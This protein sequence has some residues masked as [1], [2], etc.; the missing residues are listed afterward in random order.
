VILILHHAR[1]NAFRRLSRPRARYKVESFEK[2]DPL[3]DGTSQLLSFKPASGVCGMSISAK[4]IQSSFF[5]VGQNPHDVYS[6]TVR[7]V[8]STVP[9]TFPSFLSRC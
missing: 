7:S 9:F 5:S 1:N 4:T 3:T 2:L 6:S 8:D